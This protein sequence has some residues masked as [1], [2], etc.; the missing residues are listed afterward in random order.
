MIFCIILVY[1]CTGCASYSPYNLPLQEEQ[2]FSYTGSAVQ[3]DAWWQVLGDE[4]L[5]FHIQSAL[6]GNFSLVAAW[7]R[8]NAARA[9]AQRESSDLYPNL[10][11]NASASRNTE[12]DENLLSLGLAASYEIDLWG[13][14]RSSAVAE[15]LRA[16]ASME[17][18]RTAALTLSGNIAITWVRLIEAQNQIDLLESQIETNEK[19]LEVLRARFGIGQ[20]R[21]EDILRQQILIE[22]IK[23]EKIGVEIDLETLRHQLAILKGELP[24]NKTYQL[25][26]SLPILPELPDTGLSTDLINRRP[27]IRERLFEIEAADK[28]LVAAVRDQYPSLTLSASYASEATSASNLFSDWIATLAGG[29]ITPVFDGEQRR[30]EV[31][32]LEA[33][34]NERIQLYAQAILNAFGEVEDALIIEKKQDQR[35]TNLENRFQMARDTLEQIRTGY[36]NGANQFISVLSSQT[37]LQEIERDLLRAQRNLVETRI[38]LYR[39]LAGG[40]ETP[41]EI[42]DA[43]SKTL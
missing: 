19:V 38:S 14:I 28:D 41:G 17:A 16:A 13:R 2:R 8:L 3:Q 5:D 37:E 27:D 12:D 4:K 24:Q 39:A 26:T 22:S 20:G 11:L 7:E 25:S 1:I 43:E 32:R 35:I 6:D 34:R 36:F 9:L 30:A 40:F 42:N 18:Y 33:L 23:E 10:D 15:E 31:S 29:I 21:S